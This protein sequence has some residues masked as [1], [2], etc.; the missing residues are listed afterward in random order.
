MM[1]RYYMPTAVFFGQGSVQKNSGALGEAGTKALLVTGK[2]SARVS[3]ALHDV[4]KALTAQKMSYSLFDE[5]EENPSFKTVRRAAMLMNQEACDLVIA[6][7][8]GSPLDAGKAIAMLAANENI[9]IEQL[10]D[11]PGRWPAYSTIAVPTTSGTGSE[12]TH[13]AVLTDDEGNKS[14]LSSTRNFPMKAFLDP[15]YTTTMNE[16]I[17][18][19]TA[20]DALCHAVEGELINSGANPLVKSLASNAVAT[21]KGTLSSVLSSPEDIQKRGKLQYAAMLAGMVIAHTGTSVV[22]PAGYPLSVHKDIKHGLANSLFLV[23]V[24]RY[25][26]RKEAKRI[27]NAIEPF[28]SVEELE[29]FLESFGV[30]DYMPTITEEEARDWS[31]AVMN[32]SHYTRTPGDFDREFFVNLYKR[33]GEK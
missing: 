22:H 3:G 20:L 29:A 15:V 10:Y 21:I 11:D 1:W 5:V 8:G 2:R 30:Y 31:I 28:A 19:S 16:H 18:I 32:S 14:G 17:T 27:S 13:F 33:A 26:S 6:I 24:L 7:G 12:V 4:T 9:Q 23:G 25:V